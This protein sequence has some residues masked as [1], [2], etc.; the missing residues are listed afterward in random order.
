MKLMFTIFLLG[1]I[2]FSGCAANKDLT[3][4][5]KAFRDAEVLIA[6][7]KTVITEAKKAGAEKYAKDLL[8]SAESKLVVAEDALAKED[9][10]VAVTFAGKSLENAKAA[11]AKTLADLAL[12]KAEAEVKAARELGAEKHAT[13]LF[14]RAFKDLLS[15]KKIYSGKDY[16]GVLE[17]AKKAYEEAAEAR[18]LCEIIKKSETLI[19]EAKQD[20]QE[21]VKAGAKRHAPELLKSAEDNLVK[22]VA[23]YDEK[24][25]IKAIDYAGKASDDAKA[26][27]SA[28]VAASVGKYTVK[29]G[30]NLWNI[31]KDGKVLDDP[32]LWPLIYKSNR[33]LIKDP[34]WIFPAQEFEL[35]PFFDDKT[36]KDAVGDAFKYKGK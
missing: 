30:D 1:S 28:C 34:N 36:K 17:P 20:I 10:E 15:A 23:A 4:E 16:P 35:P 2:F 13:D 19:A 5:D 24:D 11:K 32:F 31:A 8:D 12:E 9:L 14:M 18:K 21:A 27:K 6:E 22:A 29:S 25:Y 3:K 7:A 33:E 26:A